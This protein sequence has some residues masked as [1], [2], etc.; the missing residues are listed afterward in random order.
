MTEIECGYLKSA[1]ACGVI[2]IMFGG[3]SCGMYL[4]TGGA[5]GFGFSSFSMGL[6]G[7]IQT[8]FGMMCVLLTSASTHQHIVENC[9]GA[10][11]SVGKKV[12]GSWTMT[13]FASSSQQIIT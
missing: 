2:S 8:M 5:P 7:L 1:K 9:L 13:S 12:F 6:V 3:A 10:V 11:F 4:V